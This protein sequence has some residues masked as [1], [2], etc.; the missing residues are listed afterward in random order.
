[1]RLVLSYTEKCH[2]KQ[3][4]QQFMF[5]FHEKIF[6]PVGP[7][8]PEKC[9]VAMIPVHLRK[10]LTIHLSGETKLFVNTCYSIGLFV[11]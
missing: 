11:K 10:E 7:L 6:L 4:P 8:L 1:M 9:D 2:P 3:Y 5:C